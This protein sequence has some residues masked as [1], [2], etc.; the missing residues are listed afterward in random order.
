[1]WERTASNLHFSVVVVVKCVAC[2]LG[3][4][5]EVDMKGWMDSVCSV[6]GCSPVRASSEPSCG[7]CV[8]VVAACS[9]SSPQREQI[10]SLLSL[11]TVMSSNDCLCGSDLHRLRIKHCRWVDAV[12][13]ALYRPSHCLSLCLQFGLATSRGVKG[14]V[15][16]KM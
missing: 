4:E 11:S 16:P 5:Q 3:W 13:T 14:I 15:H 12:G 9:I 7:V 2:G 6:E 10:S 8:C 1:M